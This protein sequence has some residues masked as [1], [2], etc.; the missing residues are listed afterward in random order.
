M[1]E[2]EPSAPP[3]A[4]PEPAPVPVP[5]PS[6]APPR[7]RRGFWEW[8]TR[9]R[10]LAE[11]RGFRT[12]LP[13]RERQALERALQAQELA[14]RAFD[15][16][17]P[18]RTGSS[19]ALSLSLYR[20]ALFWALLREDSSAE[21]LSALWQSYPPEQLNL[22]GGGAAAK[23]AA[24]R[25]LVGKSFVETAALPNESLSRDALAARSFVQTVLQNRLAPESRVGRLLLQRAIRCL[26]PLALLLIATLAASNSWKR[27]RL[28]PDL[29]AGK[30]WHASSSSA[31]CTPAKH[32]CAGVKTDMFFQTE[33]EKNPWLQIDL[34]RAQTFNRVEVTN[35][36]DCCP[37]RAVPLILEVSPNA[38]TWKEV[39]R[40]TNT[41]SQW[42][43]NFA[44]Q[45]ARY[46]RL[47]VPR[48]TIL[49]LNQVSLRNAR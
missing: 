31:T 28:G 49:H 32:R 48:R 10:A 4:E 41:F 42:E 9:S 30:P 12:A 6:P 29:A 37:D 17:D 1:T 44:A 22:I 36:D 34:G 27:A 11:A 26:V 47:R 25:A 20:E 19:T 18:L 43:A 39:V 15:P 14:D 23:E 40:T 13:P 35:R 8:F 38:E 16:V 3:N 24:E 33:E 46:V 5:V 21:N 7:A 2:P 45:S